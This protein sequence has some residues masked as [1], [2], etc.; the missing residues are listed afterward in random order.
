MSYDD[1]LFVA[2]WYLRYFTSAV[3]TEILDKALSLVLRQVQRGNFW[4]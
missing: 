3:T 1:E 4:G 2:G